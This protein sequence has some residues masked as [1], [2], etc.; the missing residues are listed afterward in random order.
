MAKQPN[1]LPPHSIE[2]E[3]SVLG[4]MLLDKEAISKVIELIDE[5]YFYKSVHRKV[6]EAIVKLYEKNEEADLLTVANE[7]KKAQNLE[8]VGG[9]VFLTNLIDAAGHTSAH[10][11]Y[12]AKIVL[13]KGTL[14]KLINASTQI[15]S[16]AYEES[17]E[18][19][20]ILDEAEQMIFQISESRL[21]KGFTPI[22]KLLGP[23][24]DNL[25]ELANQELVVTGIPSGFSDL[26][27]M[28]TGFQPGD[29]VIIA[30]RPSMGKTSFCLDIARHVA[31]E[32]KIPVGLF[33]LEMSKEQLVRRLLCSEA[34]VNMYSLI[35]G[36][37]GMD[38][39]HNLAQGAAILSEA[40]IYI[41]DTPA[42]TVLEMRAKARR[43]MAEHGLGVIILDYLQ[44]MKGSGRTE[45]RQQEVSQISRSIKA[46]AKELNLPVIALSQL[47]RAVE[48]RGGD[49]RPQLAD[50]RESGSIEQDADLVMFIYREERYDPDTPNKGIAEIIIGKQRN[51]PIGTIQL[52]F[53]NEFTR[54]ENLSKQDYF[55]EQPGKMD[56]ES[57][58]DVDDSELPY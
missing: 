2:A 42:I 45:N 24:Y 48:T 57:V 56:D 51:G 34:K 4:A 27:H 23:I 36:H 7:L 38:A 25:E 19:E 53:I 35:S 41:D 58:F 6:Y 43:L 40:P 14:R 44:L 16:S 21:K 17:G 11:E 28:T 10:V 47:S 31:I 29:M 9:P 1:R 37:L 39:W 12:H 49:K 13:E 22:K 30:G 33:S 52:A 50:L 46:L 8:S 3:M 54:F 5:T 15:I 26:D 20:D 55:G 18:S 32:E